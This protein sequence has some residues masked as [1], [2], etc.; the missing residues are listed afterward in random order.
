MGRHQCSCC[1][2]LRSF[3]ENLTDRF[4]GDARDETQLDGFAHQE[5]HSPVVVLIGS[6]SA[7]NGDQVR[8]LGTRQ[9]LAPPLL[10]FVLQDR[11]QAAFEI[12]L[13]D[14]YDGIATDIE[15]VAQLGLAPAFGQLEQDAGACA[16]PMDE[17]L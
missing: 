6:W 16:A 3:F 7:D 11:L 10:A 15:G 12:A 13:A 14:P 9:R 17:G 8:G 2:R 4:G 5:P 1:Q